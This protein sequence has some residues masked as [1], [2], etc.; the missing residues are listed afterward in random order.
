METILP[1]LAQ[2]TP[3]V[4]LCMFLMWLFAKYMDKYTTERLAAESARAEKWIKRE[5]EVAAEACEARDHLLRVVQE[6]TRAM[7]ELRDAVETLRSVIGVKKAK[8]PAQ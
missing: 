8:T 2:D 7:T 4:A 3:I 6:N 1:K 5:Q